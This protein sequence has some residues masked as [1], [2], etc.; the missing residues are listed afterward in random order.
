M[1]GR[2]SKPGER[3]GGRVKGTPN[4]A[5]ATA[6][7]AIEAAFRHLEQDGDDFKDWALKNRTIFYTQLLPKIIPLQLNHGGQDDNPVGIVITWD[8]KS[9]K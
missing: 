8:D 7:A 9:A 5:T 1:A 2:G 6:K 3:R 4:K